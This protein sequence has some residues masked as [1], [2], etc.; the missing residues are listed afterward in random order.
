MTGYIHKQKPVVAAV[1]FAVL[2]FMLMILTGIS[3]NKTEIIFN[4][5]E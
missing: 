1:F 3:K 5:I 2:S 4:I